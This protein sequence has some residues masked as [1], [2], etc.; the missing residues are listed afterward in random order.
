M[1]SIAL[2]SAKGGVGKTAAAV[3]LAYL[4]A[5][6][7]YRTLLW[8]LD[9]QAA[10]SFYLRVKPKIKGGGK[11]L[12]KGKS[13]V[14]DLIKGTDF[15]NLDL[16]PSDFS[17]RKFDVILDDA[18]DAGRLLRKR[19]KPLKNDYDA[20]FLDC[21]PGVSVLTEAVLDA[22]TAILA[23][24]IPTPLS[25][26]AVSQL[27]DFRQR[28]GYTHSLYLPFYSMVDKRKSLHRGL[29]EHP[30]A[31]LEG[32]LES[33]I[34]YAS[35]VEQMGTKRAPVGAFAPRSRAAECYGALWTEVSR[36]LF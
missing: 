24:V 27:L 17:Y 29:I 30:P 35:E 9:S 33:H 13:D 19:L 2:H 10:T 32:L 3:N 36:R 18:K 16:L 7:G 21:P 20:V 5:Q 8:D 28:K 25:L 6:H 1:I 34:P 12:L 23:P 31:L 26:N 22:C 15:E 14:D 4:A 11:A